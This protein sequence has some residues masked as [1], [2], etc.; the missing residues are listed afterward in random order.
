M[1]Q[2]RSLSLKRETL[3]EL[4]TGELTTVAGGSHLCAVTDNCTETIGH[5]SLDATCPTVPV[6][7]CINTL[8]CIMTS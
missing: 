7:V 6:L 4:T 8:L 2:N 3:A 5:N 1:R